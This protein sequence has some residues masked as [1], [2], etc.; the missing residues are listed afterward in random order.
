MEQLLG[1]LGRLFPDGLIYG[2]TGLVFLVGVLKCARPLLRNATSLRHAASLLEEGAK[3]KLSRPVWNDPVFLGKRLQPAWRIFLQNAGVSGASGMGCDVAEFI[4]EDN[5]IEGPGKAS[6]ADIIPGFCTSLGILGTFI[7]LLMGIQG[8][9]FNDMNSHIQLTNGIAVAFI[10]SIVGII[11]SLCFSTT[12]R[13]AVGRVHSAQN[14]FYAAFYAYGLPKPPDAGTQILA[15]QHEQTSALSQFA[16]DMSVRMAGEINHAITTAMSP[17][18]QSMEDFLN[19]ATRAQVDGLDYIVARFVDRM[20]GALDGQMKRLGQAIA[21]TADSQLKTQEDLRNA[22]DSI[23]QLTRNVIEVHGVSEQVILKFAS[24]VADM[25]GA[26]RQVADTQTDT[27]DLLEQINQASLRQSRYLSAL[28]EYQAKLQGS[29][30]DYT[31][32]TDQFIGGLEQRTTAQNESLEQITLEMRASSELLRGAYKSFVESIELGLAN[33]LGLFDENMQNLTR[34]IHGTLSDIQ[35]TMVSLEKAM[36]RTANA[37]T[38]E[39]E[40]S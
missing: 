37:V 3:A 39:R 11:A 24:Y 33:A 36:V 17:V 7:G 12:Y 32:W 31:V 35:E 5:L 27:T 29:F 10:T 38:M 20:N 19:A 6:L 4:H 21:Q 40:V 26:Y 16:E 13:Y 2:L 30:Q 23:G 28:Q 1:I 18:Q 9:D 8:L 14:D 34:Q 22:V 15:Y 25:E